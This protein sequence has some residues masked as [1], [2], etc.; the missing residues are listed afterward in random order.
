MS[1]N[2]FT[3]DDSFKPAYTKFFGEFADAELEKEYLQDHFST[4]IPMTYPVIT[5]I[6][7]VGWVSFGLVDWLATPEITELALTIRFGIM[8]PIFLFFFLIRNNKK[9]VKLLSL[10]PSFIL[11]VGS[12]HVLYIGILADSSTGIIWRIFPIVFITSAP[13]MTGLS[14]LKTIIHGAII[15]LLFILVEIIW[16]PDNQFAFIFLLAT[17]VLVSVVSSFGSYLLHK[18]RRKSYWQ[19]LIIDWQMTE[20]DKER[21]KSDR[22]LNNILPKTI[23][24]RLKENETI[25][26]DK[27]ESVSV[28]FADI[29]GFTVL[30][31]KMPAEQLVRQL[32][33]IFSEFDKFSEELGLEKIKTI[34][35][36]YMVSSGLPEHYSDH[37]DRL[38]K[39]AFKMQEFMETLTLDSGEKLRLRTGIHTGPLVAGVIGVKKFVYDLWG[40]TVNTASRMESHGVPGK[41]QISEETKNALVGSFEIEERG[42]IEIKGKGKMKTFFLNK[43]YT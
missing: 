7:L 5:L 16:H 19:S 20:L 29:V 6:A 35:D 26:A 17:L 43:T 10:L 3:N 23:A 2:N 18:V 28:L 11:I 14:P 30:S 36:A 42:F 1:K 4:W 27:H 21:Q 22:L 37:A 39:M 33:T 25:I 24:S 15:L 13:L 9:T 38:V 41:I 8:V 34:G 32:N 40:D 12:I 31:S